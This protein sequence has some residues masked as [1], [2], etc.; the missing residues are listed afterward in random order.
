[1]MRAAPLALLLATAGCAMT[2]DA[3]QLGVPATLAEAGGAVPPGTPF[4]VTRHPVYLLWGAAPLG[5]P[6]LDDVL[7]G[8]VGAG[9]AVANLRVT[10][11]SRLVD[12][13]VTALT[14]GVIAP[15]SVTM[16][17]VVVTR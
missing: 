4:R 13:L 8:Q 3:T 12:I 15:R 2:L 1:T 5:R 16:E 10:T 9:S 14:L 17:G 7:A 6:R 11:R